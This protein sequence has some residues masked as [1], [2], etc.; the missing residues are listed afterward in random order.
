[1]TITVDAT[2]L[3]VRPRGP[4]VE[5][6]WVGGG[7]RGKSWIVHGGVSLTLNNG[8]VQIAREAY[9]F[10][11][12]RVTRPERLIRNT[13]TLIGRAAVGRGIPYF[14]DFEGNPKLVGPYAN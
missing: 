7:V 9:N 13:F 6:R 3:T 12:H 5:G 2:Q 11:L 8:Q 14:F 1:M 4:L 10:E